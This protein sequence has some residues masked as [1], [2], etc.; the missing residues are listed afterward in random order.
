[1]YFQPENL[2][3]GSGNHDTGPSSSHKRYLL[4]HVCVCEPVLFVHGHAAAAPTTWD[5]FLVARAREYL[6]FIN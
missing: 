3:G 5:G 2:T 1:M 6:I 4:I